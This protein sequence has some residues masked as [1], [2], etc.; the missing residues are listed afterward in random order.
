MEFDINDFGPVCYQLSLVLTCAIRNDVDC[1][2]IIRINRY[3]LVEKQRYVQRINRW[4]LT[5]EWSFQRLQN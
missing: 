4:V 3:Y 5:D 1:L 2:I